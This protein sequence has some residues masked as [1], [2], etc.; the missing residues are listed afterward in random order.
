MHHNIWCQRGELR[1]ELRGRKIQ[2]THRHAFRTGNF[3]H[4]ST[5]GHNVNARLVLQGPHD[6]SPEV[7]GS[8][9]HDNPHH[10]SPPGK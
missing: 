10:G 8:S 2:R 6:P 3:T 5:R 7:P 1:R 4:P 9:Q